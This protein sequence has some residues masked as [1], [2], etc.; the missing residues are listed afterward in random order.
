MRTNFCGS[1]DGVRRPLSE[2]LYNIVMAFVLVFDIVNIKDGPTRLKNGWYY[3]LVAGEHSALLGCWWWRQTA[4]PG[5]LGQALLLAAPAVL[6]IGGTLALVLY[7]TRLH[8][9]GR[10]PNWTQRPRLA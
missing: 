5:R 7:Y 8:P 9:G 6:Q 3:T 1:I 10:L 4:V 2:L